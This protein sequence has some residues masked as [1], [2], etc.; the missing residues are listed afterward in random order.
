VPAGH[1]WEVVVSHD[2]LA[3]PDAAQLDAVAAALGRRLG[4]EA[5]AHLENGGSYLAVGAT[6]LVTSAT[7]AD[8]VARAAAAVAEELPMA[9]IAAGGLREIVVRPG[10]QDPRGPMRLP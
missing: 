1:S 8:A 4:T 10:D 6:V 7:P 3:E 2:A 5:H 9:G